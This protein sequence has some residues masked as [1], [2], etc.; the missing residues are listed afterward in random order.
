MPA[1]MTWRAWQVLEVNEEGKRAAACPTLFYLP[2]CEADICDNLV[3]ANWGTVQRARTAVLGN[4]FSLYAER[5]A[6]AGSVQAQHRRARPEWLL[7]AVVEGAV[8]EVP[9]LDHGFPIVSA[10][11][12]MGLHLFPALPGEPPSVARP[13]QMHGLA[14]GAGTLKL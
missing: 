6:T 9:V 11:N 5:W 2:H 13:L 4:S 7:R 1:T 3:A 14:S 12:D 8:L 10:F